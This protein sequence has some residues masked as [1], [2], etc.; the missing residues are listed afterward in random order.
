MCLRARAPARAHASVHVRGHACE[1]G[2]ARLKLKPDGRTC[3]KEHGEWAQ[4]RKK[5]ANISVALLLHCCRTRAV[6]LQPFAPGCWLHQALLAIGA[7]ALHWCHT[8]LACPGAFTSSVAIGL[9]AFAVGM[10]RK[11]PKIEKKYLAIGPSQSG[12]C[13]VAAG[14]GLMA[15]ADDGSCCTTCRRGCRSPSRSRRR[16]PRISRTKSSTA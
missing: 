1:R 3:F 14:H 10:P 5:N 9:S 12:R 11:A 13:P 6:A 16:R 4:V 15:H 2:C 7:W 8:A